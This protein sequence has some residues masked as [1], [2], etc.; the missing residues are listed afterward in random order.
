MCWEWNLGPQQEQQLLLNAE[1]VRLC[2]QL[3]CRF[4]TNHTFSVPRTGLIIPL[5]PTTPQSPPLPPGLPTY[6]QALAA[7]GVHDA[8]PPPYSRY[9]V[10]LRP[11]WRREKQHVGGAGPQGLSL[12]LWE[13]YVGRGLQ[14]GAG[15]TQLSIGA[16]TSL[17]IVQLFRKVGLVPTGLRIG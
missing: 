5:S 13:T 12:A 16:W 3:Q 6:E 17:A 11:G 1:P 14:G 8:P 15:P 4:Y 10:R 9:R 2:R 7:S